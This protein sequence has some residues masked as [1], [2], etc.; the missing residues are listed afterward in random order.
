MQ[1]GATPDAL[2]R[3]KMLHRPR[4]ATESSVGMYR[5]LTIDEL[6]EMRKCCRAVLVFMDEDSLL[7][8]RL[9]LPR[10]GR[11]G[12]GR[13]GASLNAEERRSGGGVQDRYEH[14]STKW[15]VLDEAKCSASSTNIAS[16][17]EAEASTRTDLREGDGSG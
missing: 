13:K 7:R 14:W 6:T 16:G 12:Q 15:T 2:Q 1:A 5:T 11:R 17:L 3:E 4:L 8:A 10:L 9:T